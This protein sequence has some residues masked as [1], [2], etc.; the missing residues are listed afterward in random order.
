M[1]FGLRSLGFDV[2]FFRRA[3]ASKAEDQKPED[4]L[5]V[6]RLPNRRISSNAPNLRIEVVMN[7]RISPKKRDAKLNKE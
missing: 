4:H 3:C 1:V 6:Q 5:H 2:G 7:E